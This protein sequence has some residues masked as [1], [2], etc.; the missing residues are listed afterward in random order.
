MQPPGVE[1]PD[2]VGYPFFGN[3]F[4]QSEFFAEAVHKAS[5]LRQASVVRTMAR[6]LLRRLFAAER[7][8]MNRLKHSAK[9]PFASWPKAV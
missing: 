4:L 7:L 2:R 8:N 9:R 6:S 5:G 3:G 1:H